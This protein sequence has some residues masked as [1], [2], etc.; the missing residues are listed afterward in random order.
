MSASSEHRPSIREVAKLAGVATST[1]S[2][3]MN[4][5]IDVSPGMRERVYAAVRDLGYRPDILAQGLRT[6]TTRAIGVIVSDIAD[7]QLA[8]AVT[9]IERRLRAAGYAVFLANLE[10]DVEVD[11]E[12]I[13]LLTQRRVDGLIVG[14]SEERY[15]ATVELLRAA[16]V[17]LVLLDRDL[18]S[19]VRASR[20]VFDHASSMQRATRTLLEHG[21]PRDRADRRRRRP[22][23]ARA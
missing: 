8:A 9:G 17:P 2:R 14:L 5:H 11:L 15:P 13:R 10:R 23:G 22:A 4:S 1:V 6:K 19:G 16:N 12:S 21:P 7:P 18:P 20:V 3:V